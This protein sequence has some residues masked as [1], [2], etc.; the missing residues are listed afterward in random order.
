[1]DRLIVRVNSL[2][3]PWDRGTHHFR[4]F[5]PV[6]FRERI[7]KGGSMGRSVYLAIS[8]G[9][10]LELCRDVR[11]KRQPAVRFSPQP[12]DRIQEKLSAEE[13]RRQPQGHLGENGQDD[14]ADNLQDDE[15]NDPAVDV[16]HRVALGGHPG[17][18]KQRVAEGRLS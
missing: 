14:Q 10:L 11:R 15:G 4:G 7:L 18:I 5:L 13:N 17:E 16:H 8:H 2:M 9:S 6:L 12:G 1:M 3:Q